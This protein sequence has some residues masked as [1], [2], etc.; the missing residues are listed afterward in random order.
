M[1]RTLAFLA[2]SFLTALAMAQEPPP[3]PKPL[4]EHKILAADVG[5]WDA[6]IKTYMGGPGS[7]PAVSKGVEVNEVLTGGM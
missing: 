4:P 3:A 1:K 7:E 2:A 5:T 6:T